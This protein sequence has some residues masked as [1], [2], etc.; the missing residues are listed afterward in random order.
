MKTERTFPEA[1]GYLFVD[2][3]KCTGCSSCMLAC[4][5]AHFGRTSLALASIQILDDPFGS[6]PTDIELAMCRQCLDPQCVIACPTGAMHIDQDHHNVRRSDQEACIGCRKCIRA[7][8][9]TP[10][11]IRYDENRKKAVK[12]DLC[13]ETP[14]WNVE[15]KQACIE[16]CPV[17]AIVFSND[18]PKPIGPDGYIVNLRG[19]GWAKMGLP[20]E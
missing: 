14:Y 17:G 6:F 4:S 11:R 18:P 3:K 13:K 2:P 12:C 9:F 10:S 1:E 7:C 15:G 16:I 5:T 8:P 20:L 19:P